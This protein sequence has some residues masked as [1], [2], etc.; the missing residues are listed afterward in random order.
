[1]SEMPTFL[2]VARSEWECPLCSALLCCKASGRAVVSGTT[3][4]QPVPFLPSPIV[5]SFNRCQFNG[6]LCGYAPR[7]DLKHS[8][9]VSR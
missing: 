5:D 8:C 1:M 9:S 4:T 2:G 6:H 3:V 7:C